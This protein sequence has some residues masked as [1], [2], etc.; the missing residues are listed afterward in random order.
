[1]WQNRAMLVFCLSTGYWRGVA[2]F[3]VIALH[4]E[5][6]AVAPRAFPVRLRDDD[7]RVLEPYLK[8]FTSLLPTSEKPIIHCLRPEL[9][10]NRENPLSI[11]VPKTRSYEDA[12]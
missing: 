4:E 12:F 9:A 5:L 2:C 6:N 1:M 11:L 7:V 8:S 3:R 10:N